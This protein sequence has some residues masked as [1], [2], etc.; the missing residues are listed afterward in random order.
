MTSSPRIPSQLA[1]EKLIEVVEN[2]LRDNDPPET[3][4]TLDRLMA[5][6][7]TRVEAKRLI[8][9]ALFR[10]MVTVIREKQ[11]YSHSRYAALLAEL[12]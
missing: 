10:E 8:S 9:E 12:K 5:S 11:P 6:G 2:Q 3:Q 4:Q 7:H 1:R